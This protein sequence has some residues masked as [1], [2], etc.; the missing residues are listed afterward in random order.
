MREDPQSS[1]RIRNRLKIQSSRPAPPSRERFT[2]R[3]IIG[4]GDLWVAR[5]VLSDGGRP[6]YTASIVEARDGKVARE[7]R[8]F[9]DPFAPGALR[10][11]PW[12][13]RMP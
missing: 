4:V 7:T 6:S 10:A 11:P 8:Y 2:V 9:G 13:E 3:R 12:V 1:E 5:Y